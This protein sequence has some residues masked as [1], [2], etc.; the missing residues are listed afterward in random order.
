MSLV[1]AKQLIWDAMGRDAIVGSSCD[2]RVILIE[3]A[4]RGIPQQDIRDAYDSIIKT[5]YLT[6]EGKLTQLGFTYLYPPNV[7]YMKRKLIEAIKAQKLSVND[8]VSPTKLHADLIMYLNAR[9]RQD[10][11]I[12]FQELQQENILEHDGKNLKLKKSI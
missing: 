2:Q 11:E 1:S 9:E 8:I 7:P 12:A 3:S 6:K 10:I 5:G 4:Q